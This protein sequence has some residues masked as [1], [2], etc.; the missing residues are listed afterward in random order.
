VAIRKQANAN[1]VEVAKQILSEIES[2]N[3]AFPRINIVPV[4]NQG[5][6]IERSIANVTRSVLYGG[7]LAIVVLL[8]FLR[9]ITSTLI[10]SLS[11]PISL[12]ATFALIYFGGFTSESHESW[13]T[14]PG[15]RDDGGQ[16]HCRA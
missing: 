13:R 10:I 6:F 4:I 3:K 9:S 5:N 12:I 1:T 7:G 8:F 2:A 15:C 16:F 14:C 11:I